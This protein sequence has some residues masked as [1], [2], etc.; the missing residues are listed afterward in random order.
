VPK[1]RYYLPSKKKKKQNK[2]IP[3]TIQKVDK[4]IAEKWVMIGIFIFSFLLYGASILYDF[5]LDDAIVITENEF[6]QKGIAGLADLFNKDTFHGFF[7]EAGK[8]KLVSG[9]R[10]R[11]FTLAMFAVERTIFGSAPWI[12]HLVNICLY[13]FLGI[14]C[15]KLVYRLLQG[16]PQVEHSQ[17]IAISAAVLFIAHPIHSEAVANIKGRD[18]IMAMLCSLGALY[19]L[20]RRPLE[21]L[22]IQDYVFAAGIFLIGLLSKENAITF[23]AVAPLAAWIF[24]TK[25]IKIALPFLASAIVF[26]IIRTAVIGFDMGAN[27]SGELMNNPYLKVSNG[28][29]IAFSPTEKLA[30]IFHTLWNYLSLLVWPWPL[31]HDYYP[32]HINVKTFAHVGSILGVI[33]YAGIVLISIVGIV[34]KKIWSFF[35]AYY[36]TTISIVSNLVFPIG[37]HMSERFNIGLLAILL[38]NWKVKVGLAL[39]AIIVSLFSFA[40]LKRIPVWKDN[41]TLFTKDALVS[42]NSAKV[43]NAAGGIISDRVKNMEAGPEKTSLIANG[44]EFLN[45]AIA[46]HPNYVNANLLKGNMYFYEEKYEEAVA[47]YDQSL[48]IDP[49]YPDA[50][51]NKFLALRAAG[52]YYGEK[53]NDLPRSSDFLMKAVGMRP[54]DFE[55]NRLLGTCYGI[56]GRHTE[57]LKYF[58]KCSELQPNNA[59]IFVN[60]ARAYEYSGDEEGAARAQ[61]R[62]KQLGG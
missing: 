42:I 12:H 25:P 19:I 31:T 58:K 20:I 49:Y 54:N 16:H 62:A 44:H 30:T 46:V 8:D 29:Y 15:Y 36:I 48:A 52:R 57:A 59:S 22:K 35:T 41:F 37:T 32:N 18:E 9:G 34:R 61:E 7:G 26:M 56:M 3:P 27:V 5:T 55:V 60:L 50:I 33:L 53:K 11:P 43:N 47:W 39:T 38:Y 21:F 2:V 10:Y 51:S 17:L 1:S 24:Y 13:G 45:R 28:Q 14:L 23:V 6:T 4:V 40:T